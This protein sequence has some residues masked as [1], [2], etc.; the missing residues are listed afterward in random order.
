MRVMAR[1]DKPISCHH[2]YISCIAAA[3]NTLTSTAVQEEALEDRCQRSIS[4]YNITCFQSVDKTALVFTKRV[5]FVIRFSP[6][7]RVLRS[8]WLNIFHKCYSIETT[9]KSYAMEDSVNII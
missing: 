2:G 3:F 8:A 6:S 9:R 5:S 7:M 4:H 1:R